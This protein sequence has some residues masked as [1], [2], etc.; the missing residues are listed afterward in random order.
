MAA[1]Q[2][3]AIVDPSDE[4]RTVLRDTLLGVESVYLEAECAHYEFFSDVI[5]QNVP[6]VAIITIDQ[7][8]DQ[9][10][11]LVQQLMLNQPELDVVVASG[12]TDGQ[13]I[14]QVMRLGAKEF[15]GLPL[16]FEEMLGALSRLRGARAG[17]EG[18]DEES[19]RVYAVCGAR[20]GVG[21]T[22]MAVNIGCCL[23]LQPEN[24]VVL[25]D[26]DLA[27]GDADVCLDI[28]PDYTL[29]DVAENI[30]R[31]D[32]QLLKRSLSMHPS[33]LYLLP[34]PVKIEDAGLIQ[35]DHITRVISLLKMSFS[36]VILDLSKGFHAIDMAAMHLSDAVLLVTQLDV[37][38]LRN[39]V[40]LMLLLNEIEG[41][42]DKVQVVANRVGSDENEIGIQRAEET[43]GRPIAFQIPNDARTM[44]AS[45]N[46]GVPLFEHA[47][48][49]RIHQSVVSMTASLE[50][51][52]EF[53]APAKPK[54][55]KGFFFFSHD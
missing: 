55:R 23:A 10:L 9:G 3:V 32:L 43:I 50:S 14:L 44:M 7:D 5:A 19:T 11:R 16:Q 39:V 48:K 25:V 15:V 47:P 17:R 6:D 34:H 37:S 33:G 1:V 46:N 28:I 31:I 54:E 2:R 20:G 52:E 51:G 18:S 41:L 53:V 29:A 12:R 35:Q 27:M 40:R 36:H 24:S 22:S 8:P 30:D 4:T 26:L 21:A 45:R 49:S 13:F 42:G 38:N